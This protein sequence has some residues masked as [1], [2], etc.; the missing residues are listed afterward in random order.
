M[1][2]YILKDISYQEVKMNLMNFENWQD[3]ADGKNL[4]KVGLFY[5]LEL[6]LLSFMHSTG[7]LDD[8]NK[9]DNWQAVNY[10]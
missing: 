10:H 5:S 8:Y 3:K 9:N 7:Q 2:A 1:Q 6:T 4:E